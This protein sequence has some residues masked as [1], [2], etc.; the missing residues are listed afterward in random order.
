M[1]VA[2][3][4][5]CTLLKKEDTGA[6]STPKCSEKRSHDDGIPCCSRGVRVQDIRGQSRSVIP[7]ASAPPQ[8]VLLTFSLARRLPLIIRFVSFFKAFLYPSYNI[9]VQKQVWGVLRAAPENVPVQAGVRLLRDFHFLLQT[10]RFPT[11]SSK[12]QPWATD[13]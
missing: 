11:S 1:Q 13:S 9:L 3:L 6:R 5:Q 8:L 2:A 4:Q 10:D 7:P 12:H